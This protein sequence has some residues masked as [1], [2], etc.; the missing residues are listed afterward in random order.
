MV[1]VSVK[2]GYWGMS[3]ESNLRVKNIHFIDT[4]LY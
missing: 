3:E 2:L 1:K 4:K